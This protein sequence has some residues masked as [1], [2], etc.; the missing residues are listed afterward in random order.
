MNSNH[1]CV[2]LRQGTLSFSIVK[3]WELSKNR[4]KSID[5]EENKVVFSFFLCL[6]S[7]LKE[8]CS[9]LVS[10]LVCS[11]TK[12]NSYTKKPQSKE[13]GG[14]WIHVCKALRGVPGI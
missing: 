9:F 7:K 11:D 10:I 5:G 12:A 8:S 3:L 14:K 1:T 2:L 6:I 13:I 4:H